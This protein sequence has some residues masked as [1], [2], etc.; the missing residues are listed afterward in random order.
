MLAVLSLPIV[1]YGAGCDTDPAEGESALDWS[2][3]ENLAFPNLLASGGV[4]QFVDGEF[5]E[6]PNPES[7]A[8]ITASI[9]DVRTY[10]D[11]DG[12][13][14][15]DA[16]PLIITRN[17]N[18]GELFELAAVLNDDG[19]PVVASVALIGDRVRLKAI[20]PTDNAVVVRATRADED[21]G[22]CCPTLE[23]LQRY[24]FI[25]GALQL[26]SEVEV[27]F[28]QPDPE[29]FEF[30][31]E[32][33]TL[34]GDGNAQVSGR[35]S[36]NEI[37]DFVLE[38]SAGQ[39]VS[40]ELAD[41]P[42]V[43]ALSVYGLVDGDVLLSVTEEAAAGQVT[44]SSTQDYAI[45]VVPLGFGTTTF[46]LN[47]A[48]RDP[49]TAVPTVEPTPPTP[50]PPPPPSGA[51]VF[52]TFDDGPS[53]F[54]GDVLNVLARYGA[55]ANFFA[56]GQQIAAQRETVQTTA[57]AGHVFGNHTYSHASLDGIGRDAFFDEVLAAQAAIDAVAPAA[58]TSCLRPPY[59]ATDAY[60]RAFA[61]ELG[62]TVMLWTV[63][64]NDWQRPGAQA[65]AD[66]ITRN[67]TAGAVILMHDGGGDRS[68]TVAG[69]D[70]AL[71]SLS[72]S[73]YT[74]PPLRC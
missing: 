41:N 29:D 51:H 66:E 4:A 69:L 11:L 20:A 23:V 12:D 50:P 8:M 32:R 14:A 13:G 43:L 47:I 34:D 16:V 27:P 6:R 59:G 31:P 36:D 74:F 2:E 55:S 60:T 72:A 46:T 65:I 58:A 15:E 54:T 5:S 71:A 68:Q 10:V 53:G 35:I 73:G 3:I 17:V 33:I 67:A 28:E 25:D 1:L 19:T 18:A 42:Q 40:I 61:A 39:N 45:R 52:L 49:P 9:A 30:D 38:A 70:I 26:V 44:V 22:A 64:T 24:E 56:V 21:D 63:D 57:N 7:S 37:A 48:L 62:Y